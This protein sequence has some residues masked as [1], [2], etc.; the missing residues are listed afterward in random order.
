LKRDVLSILILTCH[1]G[2]EFNLR[3]KVSVR[4]V[5]SAENRKE[6]IGKKTLG[7]WNNFDGEEL[8]N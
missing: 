8:W 4:V 7:Q 3:T 1:P 5:L 2:G 6:L